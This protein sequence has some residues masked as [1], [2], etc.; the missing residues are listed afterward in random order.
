MAQRENQKF[1]CGDLAWLHDGD[2]TTKVR[3]V[4][5]INDEDGKWWYEVECAEDWALPNLITRE[6]PQ[7]KL[8]PVLV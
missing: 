5:C 2:K 3:I 6:V 1:G 8:T 7:A 4:E